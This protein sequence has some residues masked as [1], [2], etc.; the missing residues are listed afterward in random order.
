MIETM[1]RTLLTSSL[2]LAAVLCGRAIAQDGYAL[3]CNGSTDYL[4]ADAH[5]STTNNFTMEAWIYPTAPHEIDREPGEQYSGMQGQHYVIYPTHGAAWGEGHAGA[6]FSA[7][8]N[9]VSIYE[10][11]GNY[12]PTV[13]TY[14]APISGW[15]HVAVVYHDGAPDLYIN[16][17][18]VKSGAKSPMKYIHPSGGSSREKQWVMGGIG[19][20]PFGFFEGSIDNVRIWN[21]ARTGEQVHATMDKTPLAA[22]GLALSY[23]MNRS[24]EGQGLEVANSVRKNI[25]GRTVGTKRTPVFEQVAIA[26]PT[27]GGDVHQGTTLPTDLK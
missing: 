8:T 11:A 7:G 10:H 6:G 26:T 13:L 17:K 16:G 22:P 1:N 25:A 12:I 21:V 9:G 14:E 27:T 5:N 3:R 18:L 4:L 15:T 2:L 19:G 24:G 20:G 23:D